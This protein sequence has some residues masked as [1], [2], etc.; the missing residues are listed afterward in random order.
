MLTKISRGIRVHH[1]SHN[2]HDQTNKSQRGYLPTDNIHHVH[3]IWQVS[4]KVF[5]SECVQHFLKHFNIFSCFFLLNWAKWTACL[6]W[7]CLLMYMYQISIIH[8]YVH[9]CTDETEPLKHIQLEGPTGQIRNQTPTF[10]VV[11]ANLLILH[12]QMYSHMAFVMPDYST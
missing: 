4:D 5:Q 6:N 2:Q 8:S 10:T 1:I 7:S 9:N 3:E 11:H 12:V